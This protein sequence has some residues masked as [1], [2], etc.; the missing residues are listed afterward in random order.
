MIFRKWGGGLVKGCSEFF[1]KFIRFGGAIRPLVAYYPGQERLVGEVSLGPKLGLSTLSCRWW[2][3]A[4]ASARRRRRLPL[5][6]GWTR[7]HQKSGIW[8]RLPWEQCVKTHLQDLLIDIPVQY[9]G[10]YCVTSGHK[11]ILD[12]R[13][14][15]CQI[16]KFCK[17]E[18]LGRERLWYVIRDELNW[19][20][21]MG[22]VLQTVEDHRSLLYLACM[23][24]NMSK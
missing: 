11:V 5:F 14:N 20:Q 9:R 16:K 24:Q 6:L 1:R 15:S 7:L 22:N 10:S 17:T 23:V 21:K 18:F 8:E 13:R 3:Q 19:S 12:P 4:W 2:R